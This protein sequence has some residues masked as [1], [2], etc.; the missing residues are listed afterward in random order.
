YEAWA[1]HLGDALPYEYNENFGLGNTN[2]QTFT[3]DIVMLVL[4]IALFGLSIGFYFIKSK[5][6]TAKTH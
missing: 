6:N 4:V 5:Q 1:L 3:S 2:K